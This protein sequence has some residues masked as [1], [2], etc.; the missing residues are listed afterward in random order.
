MSDLL[1]AASAALG[2]PAE[3]VRRSAAARAAASGAT[4]DDILAAWSGGAPAPSAPP[5]A[6]APA[7]EAAVEPVADSKSP[8]PAPTPPP[9]PVLEVATPAPAPV[10]EA[11]PEPDLEPV[12]LGSRVRT[13]LRI[14]AW[15]GAG[16]GVVAFL[17]ASAF[18]APNATVVAD[19]GPVVQLT[20]RSLIIGMALA[21]VIFGAVVAGVSRA[22]TGWSDPAMALSGSKSRTAWIGAGLGLVLG[23]VAGAMLNGF[24]TAVEGADPPQ[25]QLPVLTALFVMIL[26]GA[27]L[28]AVT[29]VVPQLFGVPVAVDER[30][31][32]EVVVVRRRLGNAMS[33]PLA[34]LLLLV[35]LVLPFA[36]LLIQSNHL[37]PG[38][39]GAIV[40]I[41]TASGI[42]GFA[43]LA[44]S[45]PQM[46]ISFGDVMWALLGIGTVLVIII[47]VLLYQ[48]SGESHDEPAEGTAIVRLI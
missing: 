24:G 33:V 25:T 10:P 48:S 6:A 4:V 41:L 36:F 43:A 22:A 16:I 32:D 31:S 30:D 8:E 18:W 3:L 14:G 47:S 40:A 44:G 38:L 45:K 13:A 26:G 17:A 5:A 46:R 9:V 27:V 29:A 34:G 15:T 12:A 28:G 42:L 35:V 1:E 7:T 37:A 2:T 23:V 11:E 21:S 20:P 39:G 19:S